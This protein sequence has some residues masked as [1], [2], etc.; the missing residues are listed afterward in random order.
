VARPDRGGRRRRRE[1]PSSVH[2]KF[3][4][5]IVE[6]FGEPRVDVYRDAPSVFNGILSIR[7]YRV[8]VEIV[9]EDDDVLRARLRKLWRE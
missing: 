1:I 8:T 3:H 6:G 5:K 4:T 9:P 7:R 2:P